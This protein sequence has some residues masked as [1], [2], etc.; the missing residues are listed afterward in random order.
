MI[1]AALPFSVIMALMTISLMKTLTK[2]A[3]KLGMN[4]VPVKI[5]K[6]KAETSA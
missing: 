5:P 2:D 4:Q 1:I 3:E 6:E